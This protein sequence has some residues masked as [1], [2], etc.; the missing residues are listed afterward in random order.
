MIAQSAPNGRTFKT[1]AVKADLE[2]T[3]EQHAQMLK[4]GLTFDRTVPLRPDAHH[5]HVIVRDRPSGA[6]G[7]L[8][9]P[10]AGLR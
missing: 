8:I 9:I 6:V 3:D 1:F 5:L 7:S 2:L 4:D 10:I